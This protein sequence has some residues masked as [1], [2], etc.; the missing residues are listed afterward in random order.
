[1]N[2]SETKN[3]LLYI[4]E[5]MVES[6]PVLTE[7][8]LKI[9]DGDHG[10]GMQR[11]FA[12]VRDL[13]KTE[14]FQPKDIGELFVTVGTKMMSSMGG[15]SGA[16]FGTLFRAGGKAIAGTETFDTK[17]LTQFLSAGKEG[18]FNR[19][20][21]KPGDKTMM[22]AL[23]AATS[24]AIAVQNESLVDAVDLIAIAAEQ[25]AE[26]TKDQI[27]VFGRAKS[28]GERSLGHV[29]PG[30]VS[31]SFILKYMSEFIKNNK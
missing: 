25:G 23:A 12:A 17:I 13:L 5:K 18:V 2:V 26:S 9:G 29:D 24:K 22:D 31:M 21:A 19:G 1:M 30:A 16:I 10:L 8:D 6:E 20:G 14:T 28:L 3:L 11:G 4:A 7:L 27:A 15:A